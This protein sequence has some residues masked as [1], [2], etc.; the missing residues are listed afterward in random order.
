MKTILLIASISL[1]VFVFG[2]S[3]AKS[4]VEKLSH[5]IKILQAENNKLKN[6]LRD[7][8]TSLTASLE[9]LKRLYRTAND[10]IKTEE[11]SLDITTSSLTQLNDYTRTKFNRYRGIIKT[12]IIWGLSAIIA[13]GIALILL[14]LIVRKNTN[15]IEEN[16]NLQTT[17]LENNA[18]KIL[19][20][21]NTDNEAM[22]AK[23]NELNKRFIN[24]ITDTKNSNEN[25][26]NKAKEQLKKDIT[27]S[28][29]LGFSQLIEVKKE[30]MEH[31][32]TLNEKFNIFEK[33][34]KDKLDTKG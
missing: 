22:E 21:M 10:E 24:Q 16:F 18:H 3:A 15:Q 1:S 30:T 20:R 8:I 23:I 27:Y 4:E 32:A 2:Q 9:N 29:Q 34:L 11:S 31:F 33:V 6:E 26:I 17:S 25:L 13:F 14:F 19:Q 7:S 5:N 28:S 12:S